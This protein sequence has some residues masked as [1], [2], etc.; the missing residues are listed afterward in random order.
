MANRLR[1]LARAFQREDAR[2][3][4]RCTRALRAL[5]GGGGLPTEGLAPGARIL[6]RGVLTSRLLSVGRDRPWPY[7]I[8][9]QTDPADPGF[10]PRSIL[11]LH[12]NVSYRNWTTVG[13]PGWER[14]AVVDPG[15]WVT[16]IHDG[17]SIAVWI[18]DAR[19]MYTLGPLPGWGTDA[20][21]EL[22]QERLGDQPMIRTTARRAD[23]VVQVDVFPAVVQG[24]V[25]FGVTARV[26][27][28]APAPRPVRIGFAIRPANPEGAAPLFKLERREDGW[29]LADDRPYA[30]V[31]H[32]GNE[33]YLS[34]W[35]DGDVYQ[36][37]GGVLRDN[38]VEAQRGARADLVECDVGQ[39]TGCE[40]Y[41]LNLSPGD[42]FKRT[43]Y[44]A[45][46]EEVGEA[47]R[48]ASATRLLRGSRA[49][50]EGVTRA[51]A[52]M[53]LP[54]H[55]ALFKSCRATLLALVDADTV[56]PGPST[57]TTFWYRDAAYH[58]AALA[59]LGFLRR[60]RDVLST[61]PRRQ[62]RSGA[63][64]SQNG[65][66]DG[67]GQAIWTLVDYARLSGDSRL[68]RDVWPALARAGRWILAT[69]EDSLMPAGWS[70][71]HLGPADRYYWDAIWACAGLREVSFAA[72]MLGREAEAREFSLAHGRMLEGLRR[73]MGD[74]P[75]PAAPGRRMDS[76]ATSALVG[77]W[78]LGIFAPSEPH[79][80]STVDWLAAHCLHGQ[81]LF[82]DVVH[83]GVNPYLTCHLAQC[84]LALNDEG[85]TRHLDYLAEHA[86][87]TGCWPEA[88]HPERGGVMGDGDYA[89]A[90]ADYAMLC[91]NLVIREERGTLHLFQGADRRW[92]D[93]ETLLEGAPTRFGP[94]QLHAVGGEVRLNAEWRE[95]PDKIVLHKPEG[96]PGYLKVGDQ[97]LRG[98][99]R[100]LELLL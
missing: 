7:A 91:R 66:W 13:L 2:F 80:R 83:C 49:D 79:M 25:V 53:E 74:G 55:D 44:A 12:L 85:C 35:R 40:I 4:T 62:A 36:R 46:N 81:G 88:F 57:Y 73:K 45:G 84:R 67:T 21:G 76:A 71:E 58:L 69:E 56:T 3:V 86:S 32:P 18:G 94:V 31:P 38:S 87:P 33:V 1:D 99:S 22:S 37:I 28:D 60:A 8:A 20:G 17:P 72:R 16:P 15:G 48:Q 19:R 93:R 82:H 23:V 92:W 59:R 52:R 29:W 24:Q 5:E 6:T 11:P 42:T 95:K 54:V 65:E 30:F 97:E 70:A 50:W 77:V 64:L 100:E 89:W 75:V 98:E 14:E 51:G 43:L 10:V 34:R 26:R 9:R 61:Y 68:L 47:L 27:L 39:A 90:A 41:R 96:E 78:P 63:W